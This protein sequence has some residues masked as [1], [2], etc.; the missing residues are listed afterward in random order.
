MKTARE[1]A[2]DILLEVERGGMS[3]TLLRN[4]LDEHPELDV[5]DR[6]MVTRL[7]RGTLEHQMLLDVKLNGISKTPVNKMKPWIRC[8]MR[9]S[10]YQMLY[11][12]SVPAS[13]VCN[14]AVK[15]TEKRKFQGLKPFVNGVLR[16]LATER[17]SAPACMG[18]RTSASVP[19]CMGDRTSATCPASADP[20]ALSL[21][22]SIPRWLMD[23]FIADYGADTTVAFL[24]SLSEPGRLWARMLTSNADRMT[25][26]ESLASEGVQTVLREDLP[27]AV[28][29]NGIE[30]VEKLT[31]FRKG[32]LQIQDL[33]SIRAIHAA[34]IQPGEKILDV[35]AA[36]GG[37]SIAAADA[38][39]PAGSVLACDISREKTDL[40]RENVKRAEFSW[41]S[42]LEQDALVFRD[43]FAEAFDLVIADL[44]CSGLGTIGHKP[45]IRYR[46][47]PE[48]IRELADL[49]WRILQNVC[50]YVR[51]GGRLLFS[52]CSVS[53]EENE[54][55]AEKLAALPDFEMLSCEQIFP[56]EGD[57][58]FISLFRRK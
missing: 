53:R 37:K 28:G 13:A 47:T 24:E 30:S 23:R 52:T 43:V 44:P 11:L 46:V 57:G 8:L 1:L 14:E 27:E 3:H 56:G 22:Y 9:M 36:P 19:A 58:F 50:R 39:G 55:N 42:V 18:D 48:A 29:L 15:L 34:G 17:E 2:C 35:C 26:L 41:I 7:V 32:Y 21:R 49:Q 40:I 31:A 16:K 25:I 33:S 54:E 38:T 4:T 20:D 6:H 51:P 12:D 10:A 5:R 45:E